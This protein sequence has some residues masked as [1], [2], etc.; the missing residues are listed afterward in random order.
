MMPM[1]LNFEK[2]DNNHLQAI[3]VSVPICENCK[4]LAVFHLKILR[5]ICCLHNLGHSGAEPL[6]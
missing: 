3:V 4:C 2:E 5:G 1:E 6:I